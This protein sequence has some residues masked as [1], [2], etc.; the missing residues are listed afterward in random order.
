MWTLNDV[1]LTCFEA[2]WLVLLVS[3]PEWWAVHDFGFQHCTNTI[4][5]DVFLSLKLWIHPPFVVILISLLP[6]GSYLHMFVL[7][8]LFSVVIFELILDVLCHFAHLWSHF[9]LTALAV[10]LFEVVLYFLL[11]FLSKEDPLPLK[12]EKKNPGNQRTHRNHRNNIHR[13]R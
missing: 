9:S 13:G 8:L 5:L 11:F 7:L 1:F 12:V 4:Q 10:S 2:H 3:Q 6:F